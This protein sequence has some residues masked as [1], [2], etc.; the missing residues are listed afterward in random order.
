MVDVY[1]YTNTAKCSKEILGRRKIDSMAMNMALWTSDRLDFFSPPSLGNAKQLVKYS[2]LVFRGWIY[3]M[4]V[5]L[6]EML[7]RG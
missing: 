3:Q 6:Q 4:H 7:V 1:I 5:N 2:L